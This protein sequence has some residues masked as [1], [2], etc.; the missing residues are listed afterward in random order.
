MQD[1][2]KKPVFIVE[3]PKKDGKVITKL[4]IEE[5]DKESNL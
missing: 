5:E 4:K 3:N 1:S 2:H